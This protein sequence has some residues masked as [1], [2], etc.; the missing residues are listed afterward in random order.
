MPVFV[1]D[2]AKPN[3]HSLRSHTIDTEVFAVIKH[4]IESLEIIGLAVI[5]L[6]CFMMSNI[7]FGTYCNVRIHMHKFCFK[8]LALGLTKLMC[9]C[10]GLCLL[11]FGIV[12]L[13]YWMEYAGVELADDITN[14]YSIAS[15][16]MV[17]V[18]SI[19]KYAK[20]SFAKLNAIL[21]NETPGTKQS[22]NASDQGK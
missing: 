9:L 4:I 7:C 5:I 2:L 17:F 6:A 12:S 21:D 19:V 3:T 20:K 13:P 10:F 8:K 14:T 15:V 11:V 1:H 18:S 16:C 22:N